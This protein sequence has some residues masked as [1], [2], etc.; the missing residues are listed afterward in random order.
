[1][2]AK[3]LY[4]LRIFEEFAYLIRMI[5]VVIQDMWSFFVVLFTVLLAFTDAFYGIA[6]V[7]SKDS[8][9]YFDNFWDTFVVTYVMALGDW[10]VPDTF[11]EEIKPMMQALFLLSTIF[12]LIVLLNLLIYIISESAGKVAGSG[13]QFNYKE[14]A[15]L[16][17]D[18]H[19]LIPRHIKNKICEHNSFLILAEEVDNLQINDEAQTSIQKIEEK[20]ND[21]HARF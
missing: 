18:N 3:M 16:I 10:S 19:Y 6:R 11:G 21:L 15:S 5:I 2:W 13:E 1:M 9:F 8:T 4:F 12:N 20:L 17:I 14:K 7:N